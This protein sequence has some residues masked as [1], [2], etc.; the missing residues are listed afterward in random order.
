MANNYVAPTIDLICVDDDGQA[1]QDVF[2][3]PADV[4][5]VERDQTVNII[6]DVEHTIGGSAVI[7]NGIMLGGIPFTLQSRDG[8]WFSH[9]QRTALLNLSRTQPLKKFNLTLAGETIARELCW[10][11]SPAVSFSPILDKRVPDDE[12]F[13]TGTL[14]FLEQVP[15]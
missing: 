13:Y 2:Q 7:N 9:E 4:L 11:H 12:T 6:Q 8:V 10:R 1:T 14:Q 3:I 15:Q 5:W